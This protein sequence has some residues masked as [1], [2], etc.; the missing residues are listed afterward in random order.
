[1][2]LSITLESFSEKKGISSEV[3]LF[4]LFYR[5]DRKSAI[6]FVFSH[7]YHSLWINTRPVRCEMKWKS[8]SHRKLFKCCQMAH[9]H[10]VSFYLLK[11]F[12]VPFGGKFLPVFPCKWKALF[13]SICFCPHSESET[14]GKYYGSKITSYLPGCH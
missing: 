13:D 10:P 1:M 14:Q 9:T 11:L 5:N 8:P 6:A 3:F 4:S 2:E 7:Y 12:P